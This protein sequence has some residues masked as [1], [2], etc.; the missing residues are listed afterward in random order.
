MSQQITRVVRIGR[1]SDR[2]FNSAVIL[3]DPIDVSCTSAGREALSKRP[4]L[5]LRNLSEHQSHLI[6]DQSGQ[7]EA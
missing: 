4:V 2:G 7:Q 6:K 5:L 1:V 3:Y